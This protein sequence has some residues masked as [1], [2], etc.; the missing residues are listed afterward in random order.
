[1]TLNLDR[2]SRALW[3]SDA[4]TL[5]AAT[6]EELRRRAV[7]AVESGVPQ[8]EVARLFGVSRQTVGAWVRAYRDS[9]DEALRARRRGRKP[10]DRRALTH[11]QQVWVVDVLASRFPRD[12]GLDHWLWNRRAVIELINKEFGVALSSTSIRTYLTRWGLATEGRLLAVLRARHAALLGDGV[13]F[14]P[15][16]RN[17]H[18]IPGAETVWAGWMNTRWSVRALPEASGSVG[19]VVDTKVFFAISNRSVVHFG[20]FSDPQDGCQV[21]DLLIKL[22]NQMRRRTNVILGWRP[23][24]CVD[25]LNDWLDVNSGSVTTLFSGPD[26]WTD[27]SAGPAGDRPPA[28]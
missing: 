20:T 27:L 3:V 28:E 15:A 11:E 16:M 22:G 2:R 10:G 7:A 13:S 25:E 9:G 14:G 18:A 21:R 19:R 17:Q 6:L 12:V 8:V 23:T 24:R 26:G 1:M 5:S 4:R